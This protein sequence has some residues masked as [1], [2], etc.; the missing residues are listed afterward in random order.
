MV[1]W[2]SGRV[3]GIVDESQLVYKE[4]VRWTSVPTKA[5]L[6][7]WSKGINVIQ[8]VKALSL[9]HEQETV[10]SHAEHDSFF[11]RYRSRE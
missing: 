7:A 2:T 8:L 11:T 4:S 5:T 6:V 3:V 10:A 1:A 9:G